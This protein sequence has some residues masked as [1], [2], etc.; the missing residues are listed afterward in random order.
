MNEMV[1]CGG[2]CPNCTTQPQLI[3]WTNSLKLLHK[4]ENIVIAL[5]GKIRIFISN[6]CGIN[7]YWYQMDSGKNT[8]QA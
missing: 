1:L 5:P 6:K 8:I 7:G 2:I 4:N 3:N